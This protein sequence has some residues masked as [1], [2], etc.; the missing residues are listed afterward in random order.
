[1]PEFANCGCLGPIDELFVASFGQRYGL[2]RNA[3]LLAMIICC[4]LPARQGRAAGSQDAIETAVV[5]R[6]HCGK[7]NPLSRGFTLAELLVVIGIIGLLLSLLLPALSSARRSARSVACL[8]NL[9]Q[10]A[11]LAA[12]WAVDH[13]NFLPLDGE[14]SLPPGT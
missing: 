5:L 13:H 10:I 6:R 14:V 2:I 8:S 11:G 1:D 9:R 3:V 7:A 4:L 12:G